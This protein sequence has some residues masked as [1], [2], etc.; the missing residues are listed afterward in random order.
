[1]AT[2]IQIE[3]VN[4]KT[5]SKMAFDRDWDTQLEDLKSVLIND[6]IAEGAVKTFSINKRGDR[7]VERIEWPDGVELLNILKK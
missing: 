7:A 1:M 2:L 3:K 4:G 5:V 6:A